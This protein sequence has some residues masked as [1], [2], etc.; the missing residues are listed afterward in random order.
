MA[1]ASAKKKTETKKSHKGVIAAGLVLAV[2][3]VSIALVMNV[4]GLA[5]MGVERIS[6]KTLG[7]SVSI[8]SLDIS[9]QN[10]Q[11]TV[12][13]LKVGNPQGYSQPHALTIDSIVIA[14]EDM[15][16][17]LLV[18]N[19]IKASG[20]TL[21]LEVTDK[22][23]NFMD[24]RANAKNNIPPPDAAKEQAKVIVRSVVLEKATLNPGII[25]AGTAP[26][27][28]TLPD[29][30]IRGIGEQTNGVLAAEAIAQVVNYVVQVAMKT[31]LEEGYLR[32][33]APESLES[34]QTELGLPAGFMGQVKDLGSQIKGLF[35]N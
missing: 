2:I 19:E 14:A 16:Q 21:N 7:A 25:L 29:I 34:I 24:L 17:D 20:A 33:M 10:K 28:V 1:K 13:G 18:F 6:S 3:A 11:I 9:L 31:S 35:D 30:R 32:G 15:K 5:K 4:G 8:A 23:S 22:S 27:P 12:S 26:Q